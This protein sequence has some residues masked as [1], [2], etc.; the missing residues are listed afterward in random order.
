MPLKYTEQP[1]WIKIMQ[2]LLSV[3]DSKPRNIYNTFRLNDVQFQAEFRSLRTIFLITQ[4]EN[5]CA[6]WAINVSS[7]GLIFRPKNTSQ[8]IWFSLACPLVEKWG[9]KLILP[10]QCTCLRPDTQPRCT[11]LIET[12][13]RYALHIAIYLVQQGRRLVIGRRGDNRAI[14]LLCGSELCS[15]YM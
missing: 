7:A 2:I 1:K 4:L 15:L 5:W 8:I 3:H 14:C 13:R 11:P 12:R 9:M 6:W 10:M